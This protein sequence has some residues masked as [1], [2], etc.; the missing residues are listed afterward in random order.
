MKYTI[1]QFLLIVIALGIFLGLLMG[2]Y[3]SSFPAVS[4]PSCDA[5]TNERLLHDDYGLR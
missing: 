2:F 4:A 3:Y 5:S 1:R